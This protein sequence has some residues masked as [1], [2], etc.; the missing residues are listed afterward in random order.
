MSRLSSRKMISWTVLNVFLL[1]ATVSTEFYTSLIMLKTIIGAERDIPIM[2]NNYVKKESGKLDYLKKFVQEIKEHSEKAIRYDKQTIKHPVNAFLMMKEMITH[3]NKIVKIMRSNSADDAIRNMTRQKTIIKRINY[4]TEL[5]FDVGNIFCIL[6]Y[7]N[8]PRAKNNIK[9]Y[10]DLLEHDG[11]QHI[12]MRRDIP[13]I[14]NVRDE[15]NDLDEGVKLTYEALCREEVPVAAKTHWYCYYKIDHPYLRL[16]PFKVEIVRQNPLIVLIYDIMSDEETR[17]IQMLAVPKALILCLTLDNE[18]ILFSWD[19]EFILSTFLKSMKH[20]IIER[21][22]RRL[23]LAT[24]LGIKT[25]ENLKVHNYGIGG[26]FGPHFD[27]TL[28]SVTFAIVLSPSSCFY[29][30]M[31]YFFFQVLLQNAL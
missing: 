24:N 13:P 25:A 29:A 30:A 19:N 22:D 3:W 17:I 14:N 11:V 20:E 31:R 10:E 2:I 4:P 7:P 12:D 1:I 8:H 9:I 18:F 21:I 5:L 23:E 16:A 15:K 28:I 27:T 6:L 26:Y